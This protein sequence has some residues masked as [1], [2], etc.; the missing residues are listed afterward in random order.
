VGTGLENVVHKLAACAIGINIHL[1]YP[2]PTLHQQPCIAIQ[3]HHSFRESDRETTDLKIIEKMSERT[4]NELSPA[5]L[6]RRANKP[7]MEKKRRERINSCLSELKHLVLTAM[8]KDTS[9]H[10]KLEKADILEMTV[11]HLRNL[12]R[13]QISA[14]MTVDPSVQGKY[15]AGFQECSQEVVRYL[16]TVDGVDNGLKRRM[17][18]QLAN[19]APHQV[20]PTQPIQVQIPSATQL[21]TSYT[22]T[23]TLNTAYSQQTSMPVFPGT[24]SVLLTPPGLSD[25]VLIPGQLPNGDVAYFLQSSPK[26]Q[27][28]TAPNVTTMVVPNQQQTLVKQEIIPSPPPSVAPTA[29]PHS[30]THVASPSQVGPMK[31]SVA[32]KRAER[33][34]RPW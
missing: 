6:A 7:L 20:A 26:G 27:S 8:K 11:K 5:A 21:N 23:P 24:Q 13:N 22:P 32:E 28:P 30:Q 17:I 1:K 3:S 10:S 14:A 16:N 31:N 29:L 34:W 18:G 2:F 33:V 4:C 9:Y 25:S 15:A 19:R 12:Q